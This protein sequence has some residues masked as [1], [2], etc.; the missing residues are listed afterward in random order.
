MIQLLDNITPELSET[1]FRRGQRRHYSP[2]QEILTEGMPVRFLP[3][4]LS[5]SVK[6]VRS[7]EAGKE[8][9]LEIF[10]AGQMFAVA[11]VFDG[12]G[13]L[14]SAVAME[15]TELLQ[16]GKSDFFELLDESKEFRCAVMS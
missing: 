14:A 7:P 8:I 13:C 2:N 3:I 5:G 11:P 16:I 15:E 12:R 6:F 4:I 10:R 1:L 9:I